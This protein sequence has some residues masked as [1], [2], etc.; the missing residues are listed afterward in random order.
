MINISH[1]F[2]MHQLLPS[3]RH[4]YFPA[5]TQISNLAPSPGVPVSR[6]V[7]PVIVRTSRTKKSPNPVCLPYPGSKI[8]SFSSGGIPLPLSIQVMRS[9]SGKTSEETVRV[10]TFPPWRSE[11]SSRLTKTFFS[12]GSA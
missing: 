1:H 12:I 8:F 9:P 5:G 10:V 4:R 6:M 2:R 3:S 7:I 11:L